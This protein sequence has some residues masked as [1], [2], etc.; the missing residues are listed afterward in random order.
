MRHPRSGRKSPLYL[1]VVEQSSQPCPDQIPTVQCPSWFMRPSFVPHA[2]LHS[3]SID[4][5]AYLPTGPARLVEI[6]TMG[7]VQWVG[8]P[9]DL[10]D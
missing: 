7:R 2:H 10:L 9:S 5:L 6:G 3:P 1:L 4:F 8:E